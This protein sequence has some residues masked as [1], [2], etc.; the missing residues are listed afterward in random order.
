MTK[1]RTIWS[2]RALLLCYGTLAQSLPF[3]G[4]TCHC[5]VVLHTLS[6]QPWP[7]RVIQPY[8]GELLGSSIATFNSITNGVLP[9]RITSYHMLCRFFF[10]LGTT[11]CFQ[12]VW[13]NIL[14]EVTQQSYS[15]RVQD[16]IR[17]ES[18]CSII[19]IRLN[20]KTRYAKIKGYKSRFND[21][22]QFYQY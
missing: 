11:I 2:W 22:H 20:I 19:R 3:I 4:Q 5:Y 10:V 16:M 14:V 15:V 9:M 12:F 7:D 13:L 17:Q 6:S 21:T 1:Y 8:G 18:L